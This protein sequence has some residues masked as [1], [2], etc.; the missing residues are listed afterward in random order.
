M[1][2]GFKVS[3][4]R[5]TSRSIKESVGSGTIEIR[6]TTVSALGSVSVTNE[7][8]IETPREK[9]DT[10]ECFLSVVE[11]PNLQLIHSIQDKA[12]A[13]PKRRP[14]SDVSECV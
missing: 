5:E 10:C 13:T 2:I 12:T 1:K 8:G 9:P 11:R 14:Y 7:T 3:P 6:G 4:Q